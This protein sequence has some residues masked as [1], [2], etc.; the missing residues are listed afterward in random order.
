MQLALTTQLCVHD[1]LIPHKTMQFA[2]HVTSQT[3]V[4]VPQAVM[5]LPPAQ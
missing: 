3:L 4:G 1:M 2:V 5:Q